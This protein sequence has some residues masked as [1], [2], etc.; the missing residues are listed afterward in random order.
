[1]KKLQAFDIVP[2]QQNTLNCAIFR[3]E[4]TSKQHGNLG[5]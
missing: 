1:M 3:S 5:F 4:K 2:I